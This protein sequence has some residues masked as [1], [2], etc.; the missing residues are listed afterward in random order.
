MTTI[1]QWSIQPLITGRKTLQICQE[2]LWRAEAE[3]NGPGRG[4]LRHSLPGKRPGYWRKPDQ[5]LVICA[6]NYRPGGGIPA[7]MVESCP[8]PLWASGG[9]FMLPLTS[10]IGSIYFHR[11]NRRDELAGGQP[12]IHTSDWSI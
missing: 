7:G 8:C 2:R 3:A 10:G 1:A 6:V 5:I 12:C 4:P 11:R 9:A